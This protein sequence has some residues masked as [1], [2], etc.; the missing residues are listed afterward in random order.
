MEVLI[1]STFTENNIYTYS[2]FGGC[3]NNGTVIYS[4]N[5]YWFIKDRVSIIMLK[6]NIISN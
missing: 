1:I 3:C 2:S 5:K 6:N 4:D